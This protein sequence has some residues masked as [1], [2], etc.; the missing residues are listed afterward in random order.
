MFLYCLLQSHW[1]ASILVIFYVVKRT[2]I[3]WLSS[4]SSD[5]SYYVRSRQE[6]AHL[7]KECVNGS[8]IKAMIST[9]SWQREERRARKLGQQLVTKEKVSNGYWIIWPSFP[10]AVL[11]SFFR[12]RPRCLSACQFT[13]WF[14][15]VRSLYSWLAKN[16]TSRTES[17][18]SKINVNAM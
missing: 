7:M 1:C 10:E 18:L 6:T 3:T 13:M 15:G 9:G 5:L 17:G 16:V 4:I 11:L 2:Q 14:W 8:T 12:P